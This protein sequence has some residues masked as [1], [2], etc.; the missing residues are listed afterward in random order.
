M[1]SA[2][3]SGS[4]CNLDDRAMPDPDNRLDVLHLDLDGDA[5]HDRVEREYDAKIVFLAEQHALHSGHHPGTNADPRSDGEI[6]M[7]LD[8]SISKPLTK[9]MDVRLR[10]SQGLR[11]TYDPYHPPYP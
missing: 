4:G 9:K 11:P 8:F 1:N 3:C 6:W 7:R 10:D 2:H 5:L